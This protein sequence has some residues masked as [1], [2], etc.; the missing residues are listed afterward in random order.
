MRTFLP[1]VTVTVAALFLLPTLVP[2]QSLGELAEKERQRKLQ[3]QKDQKKAGG[4]KPKVRVITDQ[5]L[6]GGAPVAAA[7]VAASPDPNASPKPGEEKKEGA[8]AAP[9]PGEKSPEE[10]AAEARKENAEKVKAAQDELAQLTAEHD[11]VQLMLNDLSGP[12]YG[13]QRTS[14]LNRLEGLKK[15]IAAKQAE[16]A[17]LQDEGRRIR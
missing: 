5:E 15:Q 1:A 7:A 4:E 16:I 8:A 12:L 3:Q 2:A 14:N 10:I 17:K 11:R 13:G 6:N 9:K